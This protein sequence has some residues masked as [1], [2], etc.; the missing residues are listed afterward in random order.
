M[1]TSQDKNQTNKNARQ[2]LDCSD[3]RMK[4]Q[5]KCT[6]HS[7]SLID[8]STN[9]KRKEETDTMVARSHERIISKVAAD[10]CLNHFAADSIARDEVFILTACHYGVLR[11]LSR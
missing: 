9:T 8:T 2:M 7:T 6:F 10:I 1:H 5:E 11:V 3:V 4:M